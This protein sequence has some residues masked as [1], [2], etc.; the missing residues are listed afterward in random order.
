LKENSK[1]FAEGIK[2]SGHEHLGNARISIGSSATES[3]KRLDRRARAYSK[4]R[5][6]AEPG[7]G[8]NRTHTKSAWAGG[9]S[10][11][12]NIANR[13]GKRP[14]V[15]VGGART[16]SQPALVHQGNGRNPDFLKKRKLPR[17]RG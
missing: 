10:L 17:R 7:K 11:L 13:D 9:S 8:N 16:Q 15:R 3:A 6:P 12:E 2:G 4:E 14:R 1:R 5:S